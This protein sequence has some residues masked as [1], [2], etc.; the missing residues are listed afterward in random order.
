MSP[1]VIVRSA[2]HLVIPH[3]A[4]HCAMEEL[5]ST[6]AVRFSMHHDHLSTLKSLLPNY[7]NLRR[8]VIRIKLENGVEDAWNINP[9]YDSCRYHNQRFFRISALRWRQASNGLIVTRSLLPTEIIGYRNF[10]HR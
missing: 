10:I 1:T 6:Q 7:A 2:Q 3:I 5:G 4:V 8:L 9:R